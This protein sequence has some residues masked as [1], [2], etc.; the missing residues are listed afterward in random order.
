MC[1]HTNA[2]LEYCAECH[3]EEEAWLA[4]YW[5]QQPVCTDCGEPMP[6]IPLQSAAG[7]YA[8][9]ACNC[10]PYSRESGYFRSREEVQ[11]YIDE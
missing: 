1:N 5:S 11:R 4:E 10:G 8:G 6:L 2:T 9:R 7:W 3:A